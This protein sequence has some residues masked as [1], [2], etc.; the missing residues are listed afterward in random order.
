[1]GS[2][3]NKFKKT[4]QLSSEFPYQKSNVVPVHQYAWFCLVIEVWSEVD[5][6]YY[7]PTPTELLFESFFYM[8]GSVFE[9]GYL[10]LDHLVIHVLGDQKCIFFHFWFHIAEFDFCGYSLGVVQV[11]TDPIFRDA[12]ICRLLIVYLL[13]LH[14]FV[15]KSKVSIIT[16][17]EL[18]FYH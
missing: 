2:S 11:G 12:S 18:W 16:I 3:I 15:F 7:M 8:F 14:R 13:L 10:S 5:P 4:D 6:T 9:I 1:M 17:Y